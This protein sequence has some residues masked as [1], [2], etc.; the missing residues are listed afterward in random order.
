MRVFWV[1]M[2]IL[3]A[4]MGA[5]RA[6]AQM[7]LPA[8]QLVR[9]VI[10]NEQHDHRSHGAWRYWIEKSSTAGTKLEEQVET[11][12]GPVNRLALSDGHPLGA[13]A[14]EAEAA[15]LERLLSSPSE[16]ARH[17]RQYDED[18]ERIGR[19]LALLP[20]AFLYEYDGEE[21]GS[22]RLRFHPNPVYPA[23]SIEARVFHSMSGTLWVDVRA[24]RLARLE[25][26]VGE[27]V[28]FGFGILGRLYKGGWFRLVR[29][30][31][32]ATDWKTESLEMHMNIR[33]LL[34]KTFA[35][36]TSEMRG[37]FEAI[38]AGLSL[39]QGMALLNQAGARAESR[40]DGGG[41]T[42]APAAL[43]ARQ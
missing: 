8:G 1:S 7:P 9:E 2:G 14:Q 34:V 29:V 30:Q 38:P 19:I 12:D 33:A 39:A 3:A 17:L 36:E 4:T 25:G 10:Y 16:Q 20:D 40:E 13:G 24:K 35:R 31:V 42:M 5:W 28:D 15:R 21:N 32:S 41:A 23:G 11:A 26:R 6:H 27:N 37:G 22:Y 43:R 18:E